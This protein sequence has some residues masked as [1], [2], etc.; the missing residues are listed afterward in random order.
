[1]RPAR[2]LC[3]GEG[4]GSSKA[5]RGQTILKAGRSPGGPGDGSL[6]GGAKGSRRGGRLQ[7]AR[8]ALLGGSVNGSV[9]PLGPA[10]GPWRPQ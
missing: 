8:G 3:L 6:A 5:G 7:A 9:I 1:M 2:R 10:P 4:R